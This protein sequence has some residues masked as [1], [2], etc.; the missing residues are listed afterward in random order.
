MTSFYK[1]W[2]VLSVLIIDN[3]LEILCK[4]GSKADLTS[5]IFCKIS[6]SGN[7]YFTEYV[8]EMVLRVLLKCY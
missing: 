3:W 2:I 7:F 4:R 6:C 8:L 5:I 1:T